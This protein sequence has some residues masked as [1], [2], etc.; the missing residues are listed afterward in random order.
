MSEAPTKTEDFCRPDPHSPIDE[1]V[2]LPRQVRLAAARAED[3]IAGKQSRPV[4]VTVA[5]AKTRAQAKIPY[6]DAQIGA[7]LERWDRG[8]LKV[9]DPDFGIIIELAREG[10][11]LIKAHRQGARKARRTSTKVTRRLEHLIQAY[12]ELS[13]KL[14]AHPTGQETIEQLRRA[15]IQKLGL[16]DEDDVLPEET[17]RQD[18]RQVRPILRLVWKGII[19]PHGKR[20][21]KQGLSEKTRRE[22][23]AGKAALAKVAASTTPPEP[24]MPSKLRLQHDF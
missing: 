10:A 1:T 12:T 21:D 3:L 18:I 13:P 9:T 17:V 6:P 24:E 19:P 2:K 20:H 14:Q 22:M 4:E 5:R 23:E 8:K 7:V 15:V 16:A 11:W